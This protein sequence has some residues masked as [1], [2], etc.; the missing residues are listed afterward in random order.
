MVY[1]MI[2]AM[3]QYVPHDSQLTG[4]YKA[5]EVHQQLKLLELSL[6]RPQLSAEHGKRVLFFDKDLCHMNC[7]T[8]KL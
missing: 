8:H 1:G 2:L 6:L 3:V 7:S 5:D 4:K